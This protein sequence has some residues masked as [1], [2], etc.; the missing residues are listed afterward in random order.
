M[1]IAAS[2]LIAFAYPITYWVLLYSQEL[3]Y[4]L[5][6]QTYAEVHN[7]K[8]TRE[9][10]IKSRLADKEKAMAL[11]TEEK[12]SYTDKKNTL[13]KIHDVKVNYPMKAKL[14]TLLTKDLNKYAVKVEDIKYDQEK[15]SKN[16]TL[17][18]VSSKDKK[19]TQLI[20]HLTKKHERK[21]T[22]SLESISYNEE[23]KLYFSELKVIIL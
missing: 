8:T 11:L 17:N 16:F 15:E 14:I 12:K 18:L 13:I 2:I 5:E 10:T 4:K 9:A 21:F 22:F 1:F 23:Q 6:Q 7:I 19:I 3:Q 20:E